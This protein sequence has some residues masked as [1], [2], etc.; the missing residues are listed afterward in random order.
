MF[1]ALNNLSFIRLDNGDV[2]IWKD[3]EL[4]ETV[5]NG[6]WCSVVASMSKSGEVNGRFYQAKKFHEE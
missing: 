6:I 2:E 1:H 3:R 5:P 4:L